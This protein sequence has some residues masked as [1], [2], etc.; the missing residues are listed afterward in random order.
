MTHPSPAKP[1]ERGSVETRPLP[2]ALSSASAAV[3]QQLDLG[4]SS[5]S[6]LGHAASFMRPS[7][8]FGAPLY[9]GGYGAGFSDVGGG[10]MLQSPLAL[11]SNLHYTVASV[12]AVTELIGANASAM[13]NLITGCLGL[14]ERLGQASGELLGFLRVRPPLDT[15]TGL[16]MVP[17][18]RYAV[19]QRQR[20]VRWAMGVAVVLFAFTLLRNGMRG[21]SP[22]DMLSGNSGGSTGGKLRVLL[23][24]LALLGGVQAGRQLAKSVCGHDTS[25]AVI[26]ATSVTQGDQSALS[27]SPRATV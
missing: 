16:P 13:S 24:I 25:V 27:L 15:E 17:P 12:G 10:G 2:A 20:L 4:P 1:W 5:L 22:L 9:G 6:S 11:L 7:F 19:Q 21:Q 23:Y 26:T 8:G 18:E 14:V 3:P